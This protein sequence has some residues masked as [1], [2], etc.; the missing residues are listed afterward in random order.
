MQV[1]HAEMEYEE[2]IEREVT[3]EEQQKALQEAGAEG[4]ME[5]DE[6]QGEEVDEFTIMNNLENPEIVR[7]SKREPKIKDYAQFLKDELGSDV[8]EGQEEEEEEIAPVQKQQTLE[9]DTIKP[10]VRT[11]GRC[12]FVYECHNFAKLLK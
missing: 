9:E 1:K 11:E 2:Q 7:R 3:E 4:S 5:C 8:E 6:Y 12:I 10:I